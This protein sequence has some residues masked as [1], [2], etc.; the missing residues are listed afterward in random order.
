MTLYAAQRSNPW[1]QLQSLVSTAWPGSQLYNQQACMRMLEAPGCRANSTLSIHSAVHTVDLIR[2]PH[3]VQ[4]AAAMA[5]MHERGVIHGDLSRANIL[6]TDSEDSPS[7]FDVKVLLRAAAC[8]ICSSLLCICCRGPRPPGVK[9]VSRV[10]G[11]CWHMAAGRARRVFSRCLESG[12]AA[13]TWPL[14]RLIHLSGDGPVMPGGGLRH[15]PAAGRAVPHRHLQLRHHH[16]HR[17]RAHGRRCTS[18]KTCWTD[19]ASAHVLHAHKAGG[20]HLR[21]WYVRLP[22]YT[23]VSYCARGACGSICRQRPCGCALPTGHL[24]RAA[25]VFAAGVLM[26]ELWNGGGAWSGMNQVCTGIAALET[27][28]TRMIHAGHL[29]V[30][31]DVHV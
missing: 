3:A 17:A 23:C 16:P 1:S 8:T 26:W 7:G 5:Y 4:L 31:V 15:G 14:T 24:S 2:T 22:T 28:I 10:P 13:G 25:D 30:G 20:P 27:G 9:Q 6:L 11:C 21:G 18:H 19:G 12:V 29:E